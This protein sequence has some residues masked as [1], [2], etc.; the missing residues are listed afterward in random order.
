MMT[1]SMWFIYNQLNNAN[2][3]TRI[4]LSLSMMHQHH[5]PLSTR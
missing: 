2:A 4:M 1:E 5:C 3:R